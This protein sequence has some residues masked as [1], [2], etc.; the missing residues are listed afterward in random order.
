MQW[1][2]EFVLKNRSSVWSAA[3]EKCDLR[4]GFEGSHMG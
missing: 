4:S 1:V 3:Y 2:K